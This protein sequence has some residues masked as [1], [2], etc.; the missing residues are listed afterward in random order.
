LADLSDMNC[1]LASTSLR[2]LASGTRKDF[3][4]GIGDRIIGS[5]AGQRLPTTPPRSVAA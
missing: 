5:S 2:L 1:W 3:W 4:G